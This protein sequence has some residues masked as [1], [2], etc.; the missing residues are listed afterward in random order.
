MK[1]INSML[2]KLFERF[3]RW[4][5]K[6]NA[7]VSQPISN[8]NYKVVPLCELKVRFGSVDGIEGG[9]WDENEVETFEKA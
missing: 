1:Q 4:S 8:G 3:E 5:K 7:V 2:E 6:S 9:G